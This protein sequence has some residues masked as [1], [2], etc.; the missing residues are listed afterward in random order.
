MVVLLDR[1]TKNHCI[2]E[3]GQLICKIYISEVVKKQIKLK[4]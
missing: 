4:N 2:L 3:I 1:V